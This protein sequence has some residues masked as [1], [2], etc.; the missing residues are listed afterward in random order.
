MTTN[1]SRVDA[2]QGQIVSALRQAGCQV[3]SLAAVGH[4]IP[5]IMVCN[6]GEIY[7]LEVKGAKGKL[8]RDQVLFHSAWPVAIVRTVTQALREVGVVAQDSEI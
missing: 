8:T 3:V 6:H 5:D 1:I 2:N 7:L 4:G